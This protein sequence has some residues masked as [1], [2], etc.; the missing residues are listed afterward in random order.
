[1]RTTGFFYKIFDLVDCLEC[2]STCKTSRYFKNFGI[3]IR[4]AEKFF[5]TF[6]LSRISLE[7]RFSKENQRLKIK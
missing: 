7:L 6:I 4:N 5:R 1:M 2:S 3:F